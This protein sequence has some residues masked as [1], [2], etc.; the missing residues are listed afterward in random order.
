MTQDTIAVLGG[1]GTLGRLVSAE[2]ARRGAD[3]RVL[4]R[5]P[6]AVPGGATHLRVD[7]STGEGLTAAL[8]G[9]G[10]VVDAANASRRAERVLVDGTRRLLAAEAEAGVGHHVLISIVGCDRVPVSYYKTKV[11]QE[12]LVCGGPVPWTVLRAT[13]FPQLLDGWFAA[14]ARWRVRPTG[15]ARFQPVDPALVA[16]RLAE[17]ALGAPAGRV[18]DV[19]GPEVATLSELSAQWARVR[20]RRGMALRL[21]SLGR[22]GRALADGALCTPAGALPGPTFTEWLS[23]G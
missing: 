10:A 7:L 21:P 2:L 15:A 11:A 13:Q 20:G 16:A 4:S 23:R 8:A 19:G 3:V 6:A 18:D 12:E 17:L 22:A 1:T 14:A 9:V 5:T